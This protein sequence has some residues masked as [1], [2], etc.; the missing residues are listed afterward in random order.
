[1]FLE[2][3]DAAVGAVLLCDLHQRRV[4]VPEGWVVRDARV[5][6]LPSPAPAPEPPASAP[7]APVIAPPATPAAPAVSVVA[8]ESRP[9]LRRAFRAAAPG[10]ALSREPRGLSWL[11][12]LHLEVDG[13]PQHPT[14]RM[15]DDR[16]DD[17]DGDGDREDRHDSDIAGRE[18]DPNDDRAHERGRGDDGVHPDG[19]DEMTFL[20]LEDETAAG[21]MVGHLQPMAEDLA[22]PA[23]RA[24]REQRAADE[25]PPARRRRRIGHGDQRMDNLTLFTDLS[26]V[27]LGA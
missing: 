12:R 26:D 25:L 11:E 4:A 10:S 5:S 19:A 18:R 7:P 14:E 8:D 24:P 3:A 15:D 21:A 1:M 6:A 23:D 9:L 16:D 17:G 27:A 20:A 13:G 2:P 22:L